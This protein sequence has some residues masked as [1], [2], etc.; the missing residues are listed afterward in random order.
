MQLTDIDANDTT[1]RFSLDGSM[2]VFARDKT[3]K[4]GAWLPTWENG[5]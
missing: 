4:W 1:P 3:Y 5:V 2:V